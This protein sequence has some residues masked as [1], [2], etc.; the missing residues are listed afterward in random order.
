MSQNDYRLETHKYLGCRLT[1][2]SPNPQDPFYTP[3][4]FFPKDTPEGFCFG[5]AAGNDVQLLENG[6][7]GI[8]AKIYGR[9][10]AFFIEDMQSVNGVYIN[11]QRIPANVPYQLKD[12]EVINI[13]NYTITF[14]TGLSTL[15]PA[16]QRPD[17]DIDSTYQIE[18]DMV[19]QFLSDPEQE[20][21]HIQIIEGVRAG[22]VFEI[23]EYED[24][25]IGRGRN[26]HLNLADDATSREHCLLRRDWTGVTIKDLNS[27]NGVLINGVRIKPNLE[28]SLKHG[29]QI[30]I[31]LHTM[32]FKDP[33]AASF[34]QKLGNVWLDD[35][36]DIDGMTLPPQRINLAQSSEEPMS[37]RWRSP[38]KKSTTPR[39]V[40]TGKPSTPPPQKKTPQ[41][42]T[43]EKNSSEKKD[44][45][46][47]ESSAKTSP[48]EKVE[49]A[50]KVPEPPDEAQKSA[51]PPK[52]KSP[53]KL[54]FLSELSRTQK[55]LLF[56]IVG[57]SLISLIIFIILIFSL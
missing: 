24:F 3:Q 44:S 10:G 11:G 20:S 14:R 15:R 26:C 12:Q 50:K 2:Q 41:E 1:V 39:K 30:T 52:Q 17:A 36:G 5:R 48:P 8:H 47:Q 28:V 7:S 49:T 6:V 37:G 18:Q 42:K 35:D 51:A 56:S 54:S 21:P 55:I 27:R 25:L 16:P 40:S 22:T 53:S 57:L 31:G 34:S 32:I 33:F 43:E 38:K 29:D 4:E 13:L 9:D 46:K 45:P 19:K 23:K